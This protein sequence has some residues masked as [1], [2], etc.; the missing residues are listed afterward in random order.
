MNMVDELFN[1]F[2]EEHP[3][4]ARL[5]ETDSRKYQKSMTICATLVDVTRSMQ[6]AGIYHDVARQVIKDSLH[7]LVV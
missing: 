1:E 5:I 4:V 2:L 6:D 7:R 3:A